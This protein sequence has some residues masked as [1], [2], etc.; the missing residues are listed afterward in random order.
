[1]EFSQLAADGSVKMVDVGDKAV[2]ER[3][4]AA[5]G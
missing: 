1:M 4:A 3:A 2:T 5:E